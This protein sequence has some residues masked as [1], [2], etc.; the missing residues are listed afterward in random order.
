MEDSEKLVNDGIRNYDTDQEGYM[1]RDGGMK[2]KSPSQEA[3]S[4]Q[5]IFSPKEGILQT[6]SDGFS[7]KVT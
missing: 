2:L 3:K 1:S 7:S 5:N 4:M 6:E